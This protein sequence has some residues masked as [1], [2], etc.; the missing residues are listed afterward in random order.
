MEH[1]QTRNW[2]LSRWQSF[3]FVILVSSVAQFLYSHLGFNP[4]DEGYLLAGSRRLLDGQIPHRDYVSIRP[5]ATHYLHAHI[6]LWAGDRLIWWS[7]Y[8]AWAQLA[9]VAWLW[10]RIVERQFRPFVAGWVRFVAGFAAFVF[11]AHNFPIMPW[12]SLDGIFF[13]TVGIF[14]WVFAPARWK[15]LGLFLVGVA[16]LCRQNFLLPLPFLVIALGEWRNLKAWI[17][18]GLPSLLYGAFLLAFG[19]LADALIQ[20]TSH[21]GSLP[22]AL[23]ELSL[24]FS[25][26]AFL[27]GAG[28]GG[29]GSGL[30]TLARSILLRTLGVAILAGGLIVA[31]GSL[32]LASRGHG[33]FLFA[34]LL[35]VA[36]FLW[37]GGREK[38]RCA[39]LALLMGWGVAISEGWPTPAFASGAIM[40]VVLRFATEQWEALEVRWERAIANLFLALFLVVVAVGFHRSRTQRIYYERSAAELTYDLS[41]V[42]RGARG[43]YTNQNTYRFLSDLR[44]VERWIQKNRGPDAK[45][46]LLPELAQFWVSY[47]QPNPLA[48]D[49]PIDSELNHV[50]TRSRVL[51]DIERARGRYI[52]IVQ[53]YEGR[54][55]PTRLAPFQN[56]DCETRDL[57][58]ERFRK[59]HET[60]FFEVYE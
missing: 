38:F 34:N 9:I 48:S 19:G 35:A 57:V 22:N 15:M 46:A 54:H 51:Q 13:I 10:V 2:P 31:T 8:I 42:F 58:R 47:P 50:N 12:N 4:T 29:L 27:I 37:L 16:P 44:K 39:A 26:P 25:L 30:A 56:G 21:K 53:K 52:F 36:P 24:G 41:G 40:L 1:A 55:L 7:R 28:M 17:A 14:A 43:I 23:L 20:I 18:A 6:L 32:L 45:I 49:W 59:I 3:V 60:E 5:V 11:S 33:W